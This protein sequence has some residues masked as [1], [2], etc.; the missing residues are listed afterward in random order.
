MLGVLAHG[1]GKLL[2]G[3]RRLFQV[4]RLLFGA[5]RLVAIARGNFRR[6]GIDCRGCLLDA[7]DDIGQLS[8]GRVSVFAHRRKDAAEVAFHAVGQVARGMA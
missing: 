1:G 6:R 7:G 5:S 3:R 2:H 4:G 8:H